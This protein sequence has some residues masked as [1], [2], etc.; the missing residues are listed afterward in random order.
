MTFLSQWGWHH[1]SHHG[2]HTSAEAPGTANYFYILE[3]PQTSHT[4][5]QLKAPDSP[6][7]NNM[8]A[9]TNGIKIKP[10]ICVFTNCWIA[11]HKTF[12][13]RN[14]YYK[15]RV[16][17]A[18]GKRH[19]SFTQEVNSLAWPPGKLQYRHGDNCCY[20]TEMWGM[21]LIWLAKQIPH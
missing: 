2:P 19:F 16:N 10:K 18:S 7:C 15:Q 4:L 6:Q 14:H 12:L 13:V 11:I 3:S 17:S 8:S 5:T 20:L 9:S 1:L 21:P